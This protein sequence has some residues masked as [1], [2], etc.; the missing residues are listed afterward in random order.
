MKC[1]FTVI[2]TLG[3]RHELDH[4]SFA[5]FF[6]R[7]LNCL[8]VDQ[9]GQ[10]TII[11]SHVTP[12]DLRRLNTLAANRFASIGLLA[13]ARR[14]RPGMP[15]PHALSGDAAGAPLAL[16]PPPPVSLS[17]A[18]C[19]RPQRDKLTP[20]HIIIHSIHGWNG[21]FDSGQCSLW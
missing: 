6:F 12:Q 15:A 2:E 3:N 20:A 1:R 11:L 10:Q 21:R 19:G 7:R 14:R 17:L 9:G 8:G 4:T 18:G 5:A 16:H 13:A